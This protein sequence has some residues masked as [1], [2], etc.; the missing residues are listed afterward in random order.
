[1]HSLVRYQLEHEKIKFVSK[2]GHAIS[3]IVPICLYFAFYFISWRREIEVGTRLD[4]AKLATLD[5]VKRNKKPTTEAKE[6]LPTGCNL[7]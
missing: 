1:M 4:K 2:C 3:T 5:P 6:T 7:W